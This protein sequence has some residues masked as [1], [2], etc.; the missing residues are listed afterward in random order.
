MVFVSEW[1]DIKESARA[2]EIQMQEDLKILLEDG[3]ICNGIHQFHRPFASVSQWITEGNSVF[4]DTFAHSH[5]DLQ[6]KQL[7][8]I[9]QCRTPAGVER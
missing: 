6:L 1:S 7:V 4:L 3:M 5:H 9:M 8:S 2:F